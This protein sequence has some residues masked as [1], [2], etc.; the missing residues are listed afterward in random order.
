MMVIAI[1]FM[2]VSAGPEG[3]TRGNSQ[4]KAL[5][6]SQGSA[7]LSGTS[8]WVAFATAGIFEFLPEFSPLM[9]RAFQTDLEDAWPVR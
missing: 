2:I 5:A 9:F 8:G 6:I 7:L 4:R 1:W 3:K